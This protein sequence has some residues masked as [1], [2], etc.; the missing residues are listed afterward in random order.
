MGQV[1]HVIRVKFCPGQ[2]GPICFTNN[3][4]WS[5]VRLSAANSDWNTVVKT[6]E[7][8]VE[9]HPL[10]LN[11]QFE[12]CRA[13][14]TYQNC[15]SCSL[16]EYMCIIGCCLNLGLIRDYLSQQGQWMH[17]P[18]L[19]WSLLKQYY[20]TPWNYYRHHIDILVWDWISKKQRS[21]FKVLIIEEL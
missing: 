14:P 1:I 10:F 16:W 7:T 21:T 15:I 8:F 20:F 18:L 3:W 12:L 4:V 13:T 6:Q 2:V 11:I 19:E 9:P 17:N 5:D